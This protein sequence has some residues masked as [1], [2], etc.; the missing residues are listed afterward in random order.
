MFLKNCELPHKGSDSFLLLKLPMN[1]TSIQFANTKKLV[2]FNI[3][4]TSSDSLLHHSSC[5]GK[6]WLDIQTE[7]YWVNEAI[8]EESEKS[9]TLLISEGIYSIFV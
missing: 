1:N 8:L 9:S 5:L 2:N 3:P 7:K 4:F 6:S